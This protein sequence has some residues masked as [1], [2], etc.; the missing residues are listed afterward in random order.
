MKWSHFAANLLSED[1]DWRLT[2]SVSLKLS[3]AKREA[4]FVSGV[5]AVL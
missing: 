5:I 3:T 4:N 1:C 2:M